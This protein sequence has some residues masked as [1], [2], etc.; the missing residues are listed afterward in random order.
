L[1]VVATHD[2]EVGLAR[3]LQVGV[4]TGLRVGNVAEFL[5]ALEVEDFDV[6]VDFWKEKVSVAG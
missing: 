1:A 3:R 5:D 4:A 2:G 6:K